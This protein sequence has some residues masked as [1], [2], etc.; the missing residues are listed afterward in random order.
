MTDRS[1]YDGDFYNNV[2]ITSLYSAEI[3]L[4]KILELFSNKIYNA[5]DFGCADGIWLRKLMDLGIKEVLGVDGHWVQK[6]AL[7]IPI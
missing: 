5:V 3:I 1:N 2:N 6:S 7:K 4:P